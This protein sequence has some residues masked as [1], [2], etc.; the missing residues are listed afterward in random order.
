MTEPAA[1][2]EEVVSAVRALA[3]TARLLVA[4]DFDGTLAP[5]V[6]RPQDARALPV[7]AAAAARLEA[8][9]NTRV[10][11]VSGRDLA[12]L[13]AVADPPPGT[14]LVGS[15]GVQFQLG[16]DEP[17]VG[18]PD[19]GELDESERARLTELSEVLAQVVDPVEHVWLERKPAGIAVHTRLAAADDGRVAQSQARLAVAGI[20]GLTVREGKDVLE[21]S[22]RSA[23]KGG[24]IARLRHFT[25]A[26]ATF[27]AGDDVT[28]E[29]AFAALGPGDVGVKV[30]A[31]STSA[32]YRVADCAQFAVL[33][34]V[35]ADARDG[36]VGELVREGS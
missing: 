3:G 30:G 6:D 15:H 31:G 27:Y 33:L 10:A 24:A 8:A 36:L 35:L 4:L 5:I 7:A 1:L 25:D 16:G 19:P 29:D 14:L 2:P 21:F 12:S 17:E 9:R 18:K 13:R 28:D 32:A 22:V 26:T 23:T 11:Y 34:R 20:P